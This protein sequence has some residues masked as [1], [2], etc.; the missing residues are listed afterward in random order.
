[1]PFQATDGTW[2]SDDRRYYHSGNQWV[3]Y[4]GTTS[5]SISTHQPSAQ[6]PSAKQ[7]SAE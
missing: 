7:P 5:G 3:L 6:Q 2:W 4:P 1:M